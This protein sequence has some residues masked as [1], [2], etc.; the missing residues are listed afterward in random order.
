MKFII[1]YTLL[2]LFFSFIN[3]CVNTK[4]SNNTYTLSDTATV[5]IQATNLTEDMSSLS[6][7]EDEII[8]LLYR[9]DSVLKKP[10][11]IK[12]HIFNN[13]GASFSFTI[14]Q[15]AIQN[16]LFVLLERDT[17]ENLNVIESR[18]REHYIKIQHAHQK[19]DYNQLEKLLGDDD[20]IGIKHITSRPS[21]FNFSGVYKLDKFEYNVFINY[22]Y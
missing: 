1:R 15:M 5:T 19:P 9:F 3:G 7:N 16:T 17:E 22:H 10:Y 11:T 4:H 2:L 12:E 20:V 6:T 21:G 18:F 8:V 14:P 13:R